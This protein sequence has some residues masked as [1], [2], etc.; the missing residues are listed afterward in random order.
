ML[1]NVPMP[2]RRRIQFQQ[3]DAPAHFR[4]DVRVHLQATFPG[5]CIGRD[6]TIAWPP[7]SSDLSPVGFFLWG[8]L[9]EIV[10]ETPVETP[11]DL[12]G[13]I[14]EAAGCVRDTP[15]IFEKVRNSLQRCKMP[16]VSQCIWK[17]L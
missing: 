8:F 16:S 1:N 10:Y 5:S 13:R 7:G 6:G 15:D 3:D 14:V 11:E 17:K 4:T 12:V 9:Q 2:I